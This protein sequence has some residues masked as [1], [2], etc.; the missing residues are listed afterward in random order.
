MAGYGATQD[1]I[2]LVLGC[3]D[4]TLRKYFRREWELGAIEANTAMIQALYQNGVKHNN[5]QAQIFWAKTRCGFKE[6]VH[7]ANEDESK[8]LSLSIAFRAPLALAAPVRT[9]EPD[10]ED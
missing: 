7:L 1:E 10:R 8:P 3:K 4:D 5:V 2:A 6:T 9:T